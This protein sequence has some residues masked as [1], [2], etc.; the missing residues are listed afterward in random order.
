MIP[1]ELEKRLIDLWGNKGVHQYVEKMKT[2]REAVDNFD[3]YE[4]FDV[5]WIMDGIWGEKENL[6]DEIRELVDLYKEMGQKRT[7]KFG[8]DR[9]P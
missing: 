8:K 9:E 4:E 7:E 1:A 2:L 6:E 5:E 3:S